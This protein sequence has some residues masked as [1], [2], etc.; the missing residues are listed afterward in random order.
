VP[1]WHH[2]SGSDWAYIRIHTWVGSSRCRRCWRICQIIWTFSIDWLVM[3]WRCT[4]VSNWRVLT[5][6]VENISVPNRK[7]V[8]YENFTSKVQGAMNSRRW[9]LSVSPFLTCLCRRISTD[10]CDRIR[11][12][13]TIARSILDKLEARFRLVWTLWR[14]IILRLVWL[15]WL[16]V[17]WL[18]ISIPLMEFGLLY[19]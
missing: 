2:A 1:P 11:E 15:C 7:C 14:V 8:T 12:S 17:L 13:M 4:R 18:L 5:S 9:I 6:P 3:T 16:C 10:I 19:L